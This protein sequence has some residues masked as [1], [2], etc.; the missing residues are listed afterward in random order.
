MLL[1]HLQ[2]QTVEE[3]LT[4]YEDAAGGS[5]ALDGV[6]TLRFN[7]TVTI[8][9]M[10]QKLD[11]AVNTIQVKRKL[12]RREVQGIMGMK[13]SYSILTDTGG[14]VYTPAVPAYGD[15]PGQP[16]TI[17]RTDTA[18]VRATQYELDCAG[19]FGH[20]VHYATKGHKAELLGT[21]K[22]NKTDCYKVKITLK[23]GQQI[24]YYI[25]STTF[26]VVQSEAI[27]RV[28]L[29]QLGLGSM[30]QL[31]GG[32]SDKAKSIKVVISYDEYKSI[33]GIKFP[34]KE[35]FQFGAV[36]MGMVNDNYTINEPP[37]ARWFTI[38][39]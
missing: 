32:G 20:L 28:A 26:L 11:I 22:V 34:T 37:D 17:T 23:A 12:F 29:E 15:F 38:M 14:Y 39:K 24:I 6:R 21:A 36:E 8:N 5:K 31:M 33:N 27:G 10:N 4:K 3:V 35:K 30:M 13:N 7:S 2:S 9:F 16:A 1:S 19:P 18:W 25:S